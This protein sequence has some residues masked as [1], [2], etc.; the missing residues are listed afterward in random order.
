M[1][2]YKYKIFYGIETLYLFNHLPSDKHLDFP[3]FSIT[4]NLTL[5]ISECISL[6]LRDTI[7]TKIGIVGLKL[8]NTFYV[9]GYFLT[10]LQ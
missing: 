8:I 4:N 10:S 9:H 2:L 3:I 7:Y 6:H 1:F 5:N